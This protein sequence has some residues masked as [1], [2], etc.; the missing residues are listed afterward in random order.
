MDDLF[1]LNGTYDHEDDTYKHHDHAMIMGKL[2]C[3]RKARITCRVILHILQQNGIP[4]VR[5]ILVASKQK[6]KDLVRIF[7]HNEIYRDMLSLVRQ[8]VVMYNT[9]NFD[10]MK[11]V[12][13][14]K[15][16]EY[17]TIMGPLNAR[18]NNYV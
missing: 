7:R 16:G 1:E 2:R 18:V 12:F 4:A 11:E 5:V 15:I 8:L 3:Y 13:E 17:D 6:Y 10:G 9:G 14:W